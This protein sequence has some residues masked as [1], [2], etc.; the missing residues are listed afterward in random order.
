MA[1]NRRSVLRRRNPDS[2]LGSASVPAATSVMRTAVRSG[3]G[4][5]GG[6]VTR[7]AVAGA[8]A[9]P[10]GEVEQS[11]PKGVGGQLPGR[12]DGIGPSRQTSE[13]DEH[14]GS[15]PDAAGASREGFTRDGAAAAPFL[16]L[17]AAKEQLPSAGRNVSEALD[18][19]CALDR[20]RRR[21]TWARGGRPLSRAACRAECASLDARLSRFRLR[22]SSGSRERAGTR[23]GGGWSR[24]SSASQ[25]RFS[26]G[27]RH[28]SRPSICSRRGCGHDRDPQADGGDE[29]PGRRR[30]R[31]C[32]RCGPQLAAARLV[33]Q[34]D[35]FG[36]T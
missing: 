5:N 23:G 16:V 4:T 31:L 17:R 24:R 14:S 13:H 34:S 2:A 1:Q 35:S 19:S 22:S 8:D 33:A 21:R 26:G 30:H 18:S 10:S 11:T 9:L 3:S 29:C 12:G 20:G 28:S 25:Q 32:S 36:R 6:R 7:P 27:T 15:G